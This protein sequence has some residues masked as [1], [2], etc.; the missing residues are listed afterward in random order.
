M[1]VT[2][3]ERP[4]E[5]SEPATTL[6]HVEMAQRYRH[7]VGSADP[8]Y[9]GLDE[10]V[11]R[12]TECTEC[13]S[14]W[15]PPRRFCDVHLSETT[16]YDLPGTGSIVAATRVHS[17]PPFG[18]IEVPYVLASIR[19]DGVDGGIT[20]RVTCDEIPERGTVVAVAFSN[21]RAA[22]PLLRIAFAVKEVTA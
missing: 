17:P 4:R 3:V 10:G 14:T 19:L 18:G 12:A 11:L 8:F 2:G 7:A 22:H 9:R 5:P 13:G 21:S 1:R 15:F 20:H 16:W 6:L